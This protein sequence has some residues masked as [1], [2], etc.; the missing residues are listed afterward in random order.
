MDEQK[1]KTAEQ[2]AQEKTIQKMLAFISAKTYSRHANLSEAEFVKEIGYEGEK[3][4]V[5][6]NK[7]IANL[8]SDYTV[9]IMK[10]KSNLEMAIGIYEMLSGKK[11]EEIINGSN[12]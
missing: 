12:K 10:I 4:D 2:K 1:V 7:S 5:A 11:A 6:V 8:T 9:T 3:E